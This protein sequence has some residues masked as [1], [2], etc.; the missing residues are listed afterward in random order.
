MPDTELSA[1]RSAALEL[2]EER[3]LVQEGYD[4]LDEKRVLL[5]T[6]ILKRLAAYQRIKHELSALQR[7][8]ATSLLDAAG[9]HG[10]EGL[11]VYPIRAVEH[12]E[13]VHSRYSIAG[14]PLI[15]SR[16]ATATPR[17]EIA[18]DEANEIANPSAEARICA[19][20]HRELL[21]Q[22]V[23]VASLARNLRRLA[24]EYRRT[25]RRARALESV[26]IPELD[27]VLRYVEEQLELYDLEEATRVHEA[28]R[29]GKPR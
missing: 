9:R 20:V 25:E 8:A 24:M 27:S 2:R 4:F 3:R 16:W 23:A 21:Q 7:R 6:E 12:W 17:E 11:S 26:L 14:V 1:S 13:T 19:D 18:R 10:L 29:K 5:A 22:V 15:D 28:S